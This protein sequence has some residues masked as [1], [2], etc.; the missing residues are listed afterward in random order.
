[1]PA[2]ART[3][4]VTDALRTL[5]DPAKAGPMAAYMK[6]DMPFYGVQAGDRHRLA[7]QVERAHPFVDQADYEGAVAALWGLPHRE[8]KYMAI[9]LARLDARFVTPTALPLYER[10]IREGA[11]WDLVDDLAVHLVGAVVLT[12]PREAWPRMDAWIEDPH[13]WIRRAAILCQNRHRARTDLER[14]FRYCLARAGEREF[15]IRKAIGWALR[16][17]S[18]SAPDAVRDFLR[19]HGHQLA[20]L[21]VREGSRE[22]RRRGLL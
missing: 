14:L 17:C 8:E 16:A 9:E 5:A 20:P 11:W 15:F 10:M 6:T 3:R 13:L 7:R 21:S 2:S 12:H 1:M 18:Y 22:L 4:F 19:D